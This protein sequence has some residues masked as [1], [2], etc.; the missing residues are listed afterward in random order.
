[1]AEN[2]GVVIEEGAV[3]KGPGGDIGSA[4]QIL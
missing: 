2:N 4:M 1:M 3:A